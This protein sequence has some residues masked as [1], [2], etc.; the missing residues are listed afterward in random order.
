MTEKK[1]LLIYGLILLSGLLIGNALITSGIPSD[2]NKTN[3]LNKKAPYSVEVLSIEPDSVNGYEK[4]YEEVEGLGNTCTGRAEKK[5]YLSDVEIQ[6]TNNRDESITLDFNRRGIV[7]N[8]GTQESI[9][10]KYIGSTLPSKYRQTG[11]VFG[12]QFTL[13]PKAKK[14][15]HMPFSRIDKNRDPKLILSFVEN[16][17]GDVENY[18]DEMSRGKRKGTTKEFIIP[19]GPYL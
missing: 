16:P 10:K 5:F 12:E 13:L 4:V 19:L 3:V 2:L 7:H 14:V 15:F 17:T 11:T 6:V 8:D 18:G 9:F 1:Q